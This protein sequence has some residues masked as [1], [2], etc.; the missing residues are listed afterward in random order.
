MGRCSLNL[1]QRNMGSTYILD[2]EGTLSTRLQLPRV[3]ARRA[4]SVREMCSLPLFLSYG[5][6][7]TGCTLCA[8]PLYYFQR[9][10]GLPKVEDKSIAAETNFRQSKAS[11]LADYV[12][13]EV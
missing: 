3:Q 11:G 9:H 2:V 5:T 1:Q 12:F 13:Q 7:G 8:A 10:D 4:N 6:V